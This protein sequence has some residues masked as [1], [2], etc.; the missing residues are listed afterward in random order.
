ME[1]AV[2]GATVVATVANG[3]ASDARIAI[4]ALA[5]TIR[6]VAAAEEALNG[7]DGGRAAAEG[8]AEAA[9]AASNPIDDVRAP[10]DYRRAMAAVIT[11]RVITAAVER[12]QGGGPPIPASDA[13]HGA[14]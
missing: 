13:L 1:I 12:A 2:V 11:R 8:A 3:R 14:R 9:A 4:T 6:R 7:T 10:A 5:P